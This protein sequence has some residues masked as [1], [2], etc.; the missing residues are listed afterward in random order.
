LVAW[1]RAVGYVADYGAIAVHS[2]VV[3]N[4]EESGN[5]QAVQ[6]AILAALGQFA[7]M[8]EAGWADGGS[9]EVLSP[10]C[11][12]I[13]S[14]YAR[15]SMDEP[16]WELV[17]RS[18]GLVY[19][20]SKGYGSGAGQSGYRPPGRRGKGRRLF[21]QH[22]HATWQPAHRAWLHHVDADWLKGQV[23][24]GF[25]APA[26]APGALTL[27][28]DDPLVHRHYARQI[29]AEAWT[30]EYKPGRGDVWYWKRLHPDNHWL[31]TTALAYAAAVILGLK[32]VGAPA[33]APGPEGAQPTGPAPA[34]ATAAGGPRMKL[35]ELQAQRRAAR[36]E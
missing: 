6:G 13:D 19:R 18:G 8:A 22:V 26:E 10:R 33:P 25:L 36:G 17:G 1:R 11:V 3:G 16:V 28:G 9:G 29:T 7:D 2:P 32:T 23:H 15:S 27:F 21:G 24:A 35:S 12:L 34:G 5:V 4:L 31:D 20:A 30:H 14:G